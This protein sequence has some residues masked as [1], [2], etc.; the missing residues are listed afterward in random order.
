MM[1][2]RSINVSTIVTRCSTLLAVLVLIN[3]AWTV[4]WKGRQSLTSLESLRFVQT[5]ESNINHFAIDEQINQN[6]IQNP[7]TQFQLQYSRFKNQA[8]P[9]SSNATNSNELNSTQL[10]LPKRT[11]SPLTKEDVNDVQRFV[12]Y[13]GYARSGHSI[14]ASMMDA[15]PN[16]VIAH[17]YRLFQQLSKPNVDTDRI[18]LY[19]QLYKNSYNNAM[20]GWRSPTKD[21][22]GYT[23]VVNNGWQGAFTTLQVVGDKSGGATSQLFINSP[24][25]FLSALQELRKIVNIPIRVI[26]VVR[27]PYD[28]I[29][30]RLLYKDSRLLSSKLKSKLSATE[31]NKYNNVIGLQNQV[32]RTFHIFEAAQGIFDSSNLTVL[33]VHLC[34]FVNDPSRVLRM[35]CTFL[36]VECTHEYIESCVDKVYKKQSKTRRLVK[37]PEEMIEEVELRSRPYSFLWRYSFNGD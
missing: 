26:H 8:F 12:F 37:W 35:I 20:S 16:M 11:F 17:E 30:T 5:T 13:V 25:L 23:L 36:G 32:N 24:S 28:M 34:D 9:P 22:K 14:V 21:Q 18:H 3:I 6:T 10:A 19:N 31:I 1:E 2:R 7:H 27:N 33:D 4:W 29:S 15:H